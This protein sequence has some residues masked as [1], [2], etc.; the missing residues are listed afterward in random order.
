MKKLN[1]RGWGLN[2]LIMFLGIMVVFILIIAVLAYNI[3]I[4]SGS[5]KSIYN[6][7]ENTLNE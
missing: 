7:N 1:E 4:E 5:N 2:T 3:G 6:V